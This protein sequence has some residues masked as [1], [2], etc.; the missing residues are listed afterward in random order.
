MLMEF[1]FETTFLISDKMKDTE[2]P[3]SFI[4]MLIEFY[5]RQLMFSID[6]LTIVF[7]N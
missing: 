7:L 4:L 3:T 2:L 6:K 1:Y 5:Y